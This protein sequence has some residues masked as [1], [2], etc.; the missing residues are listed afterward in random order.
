MSIVESEFVLSR[1]AR[2]SAQLVDH[3]TSASPAWLWSADGSRILWANAVGAAIFGAA[4][5]SELASLRFEAK[6]PAAAE[7]V[8]LAETLPSSGQARL[9]RLR[10]F[11]AS[12]GR[13]LT[14]V[15]SRLSLAGGSPAVLVIANEPAGRALPLSERVKRLFSDQAQAQAAFAPDGMLVAATSAA[16]QRFA[17]KPTLSALGLTA[18]ASKALAAG[19]ADAP[20]EHGQVTMR[21]LGSGA[22]AVLLATFG[23]EP[24]A[25]LPPRAKCSP[26]A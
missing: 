12:F 19:S 4:N 18:T 11:G 1:D 20:T 21:R 8:R 22:S 2:L 9:E 23:S 6:L 17:G 24:S 14:C 15:C 25:V 16:E 10:G 7:I 26:N 5:I 3:A 13:T